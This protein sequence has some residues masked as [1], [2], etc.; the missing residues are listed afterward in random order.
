MFPAPKNDAVEWQP[1]ASIERL[2]QR[3]HIIKLIRDFFYARGVLEVETP[4][5]GHTSVTDPYIQSIAALV[6]PHHGAREQRYYLQTSPEYAMKRLL[7]NNC[8]PIFQICKAF[9]Q[10][11]TGRFHNPEFTML[12]WY[13]PGFDHHLLM[14]E[15][16][17]LLQ[18]VLKIKKARRLSYTQTFQTYLN[19]NPHQ[20]TSEELKQIA[21]DQ[22][23]DIAADI[24]DIDTWLQL[25]MSEV[26]EKQLASD[27]VP[28]FIYDFPMTQAALAKIIPGNPPVAARFEVYYCGLELA[29]GFYELQNAKEQR[30]RFEKNNRTRE[31]LALDKLPIDELFLA[32]LEQGL[33]DC[34]G[35]ALG[36]D[37]LIMLA[38]DCKA[39]SEVLS[40][41]FSR[42]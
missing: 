11:Q 36:I 41:N 23:L 12:E 2:R 22:Q 21:I 14:D 27:T 4:L 38:L 30:D 10:E 9:R 6:Q 1:T 33:P 34:A 15:M 35:V 17:E 7:A 39:I 42:S 32:A 29:N 5:L 20:T 8:G 18:L 26:I 16:D 25:L 24:N 28:T 40:F 31:T 37:R 19:V 13:R 3:A